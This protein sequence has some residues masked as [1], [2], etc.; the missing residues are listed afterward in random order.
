MAFDRHRRDLALLR[1]RLAAARRTDGR[2]QAIVDLIGWVTSWDRRTLVELLAVAVAELDSAGTQC[3]RRTLDTQEP[4]MSDDRREATW[5]D[6]KE[7]DVW[8][9]DPPAN[10]RSTV[11]KISEG[12]GANRLIQFDDDDRGQLNASDLPITIAVD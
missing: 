5:G 11:T 4:T 6:L 10:K 3:D 2:D 12:P 8:I 7:G 9:S 1:A